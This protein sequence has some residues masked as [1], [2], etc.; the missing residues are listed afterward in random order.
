MKISD[1]SEDFYSIYQ[2]FCKENSINPYD[3]KSLKHGV[4]LED[5]DGVLGFGFLSIDGYH[6]NIKHIVHD[7][8]VDK[9]EVDNVYFSIIEGLLFLAKKL[10]CKY[11]CH[12]DSSRDLSDR[13]EK[14][15]LMVYDRN[16]TV[17]GRRL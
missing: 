1:F 13:Y 16:V 17:Y 10:S 5:N 4:V 3:I 6:A 7:L 8:S 12:L 14:L 11:V 9:E 15:G 2:V